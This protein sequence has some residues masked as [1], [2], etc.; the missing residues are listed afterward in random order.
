MNWMMENP[1]WILLIGTTAA[2][3]C[4]V[5]WSQTQRRELFWGTGGIVILTLILLAVERFVET[6]REALRDTITT[7][8]D[9]VESNDVPGLIAFIDPSAEECRRRAEAEMP[10]YEFKRCNVVSYNAL[11]FDNPSDPKKAMAVFFV[12]ADVKLRAGG[13]ESNVR[14]RVTLFFKKK[15]DGDWL[16]YDYDHDD[17]SQPSPYLKSDPPVFTERTQPRY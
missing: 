10:S 14:R 17:P 7:M 2:I 16:V 3:L 13:Y 5:L 8:A 12:W 15:D 6:D 4:G 9:T 11:A 1:F